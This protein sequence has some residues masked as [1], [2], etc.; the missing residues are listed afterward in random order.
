LIGPPESRTPLAGPADVGACAVNADDPFS[1]A[2][3]AATGNTTP[4]ERRTDIRKI[5]EK[6]AFESFNLSPGLGWTII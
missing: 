5:V 2:C 3:T 1:I 4:L 6:E